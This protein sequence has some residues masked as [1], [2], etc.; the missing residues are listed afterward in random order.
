MSHAPSS[1]LHQL[2]DASLFRFITAVPRPQQPPSPIAMLTR[3][4]PSGGRDLLRAGQAA[5]PAKPSRAFA[6]VIISIPI[7]CILILVLFTF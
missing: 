7:A 5:L 2:R 3:A 1:P 6:L 4:G